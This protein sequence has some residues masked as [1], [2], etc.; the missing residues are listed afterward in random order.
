MGLMRTSLGLSLAIAFASAVAAVDPVAVIAIFEEIHVNHNL[1]NLVFG[2]SVLNDAISIVLFRVA[3]GIT[4]ALTVATVALA[5]A[6]FVVN[7]VA[8]IVWTYCCCSGVA[9]FSKYSY[10]ARCFGTIILALHLPIYR[11]IY[12]GGLSFV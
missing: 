10:K 9:L 2:E 11:C 4:A 12:C 8:G 6:V 3:F 7:V 1:N 5:A